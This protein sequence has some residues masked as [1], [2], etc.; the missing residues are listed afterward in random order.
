MRITV[1]MLC[2]EFVKL[3]IFERLHLVH[4]ARIDIHTLAGIQLKHFGFYS[5]RSVLQCDSKSPC[6]EIEGLGLQ[7]V[8]MK[9]PPL[10]FVDF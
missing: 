2:R 5:I 6:P 1:E 9:R 3:C 7:L 4:E 8:I 10:P